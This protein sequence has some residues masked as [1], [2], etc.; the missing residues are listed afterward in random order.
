MEAERGTAYWEKLGYSVLLASKG[1]NTLM[2][3][4]DLLFGLEQQKAYFI[5]IAQPYRVYSPDVKYPFSFYCNSPSKGSTEGN[6]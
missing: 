5:T 4:L 6:S 2:M 1:Q 3:K